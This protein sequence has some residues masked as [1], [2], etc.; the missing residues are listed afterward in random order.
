MQK[1][2][3]K[4]P[5]VFLA[6]VVVGSLLFYIASTAAAFDSFL[7]AN[8]ARPP[9]DYSHSSRYLVQPMPESRRAGMRAE[10]EVI[11][12]NGQ[13]LTGMAGLID[14]TFNAHPGDVVSIAYRNRAGDM[15][16]AQVT[17]MAPH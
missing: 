6:L 17:L 7:N 12:V 2:L 3:A 4:L 9:L 16:T 10:D 1:N 15:H 8:R 13:A 11:S 5:Y 14:Q